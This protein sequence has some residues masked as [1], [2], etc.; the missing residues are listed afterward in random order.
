MSISLANIAIWSLMDNDDAMY[1]ENYRVT[2]DDCAILI[3][4]DRYGTHDGPCDRCYDSVHFTCSEC[5]GEFHCDDHHETYTVLCEGCGD[6]RRTQ[7]TDELWA[8]IEDL[9]GSWSGD[10]TEI[11]KLQ[12]LLKYARKLK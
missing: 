11:S 3:S 10:D 8:E 1:D 2:C 5:G 4:E 7:Q 9:A 12:K 6:T